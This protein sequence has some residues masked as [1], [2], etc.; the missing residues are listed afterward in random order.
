LFVL[1][2]GQPR[3]HQQVVQLVFVTVV[4][5]VIALQVALRAR[6]IQNIVQVDQRVFEFSFRFLQGL[7]EA[8]EARGV[9][10]SDPPK[11]E[12]VRPFLFLRAAQHGY[13]CAKSILR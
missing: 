3:L 8:C 4:L 6:L 5:Q 9:K 12:T 1:L 10:P 11:V 7:R 2:L 13:Q